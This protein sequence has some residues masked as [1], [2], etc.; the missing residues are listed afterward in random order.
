MQV[1]FSGYLAFG[2]MGGWIMS[3]RMTLYWG[4]WRRRSAT[5]G[6][7]KPAPPVMRILG[8]VVTLIL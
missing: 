8:I 7:R 6:P 4:S 2:G 3:E 1:A 5:R